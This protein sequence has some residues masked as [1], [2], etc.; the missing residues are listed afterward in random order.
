MGADSRRK[1]WPKRK[2]GEA[3]AGRKRDDTPAVESPLPGEEFV[4]LFTSSQR[5]LY[6][7][8]LS[9][10]GNPVEAEEVLQETSLIIWRK[11]DRFEL[12]TNFFAWA[13]QIAKYEVLKFRE[14]RGKEKLLF[15][16]EFIRRVSAEAIH[17]ADE[18]EARRHALTNCLGKLS[19]KDRELIQSR[20]APGK[21]GKSV[22][23][24]LGRPANSVYQSLGRIRRSLL[25]C[26]RRQLTAEAGP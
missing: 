2:N 10:I 21:S 14:R 5:R 18:M 4:Q 15:S 6:T 13:C 1:L 9:Q 24:E 12:G 19:P 3:V 7:F 22:S 25:E 8:I 23:Q 20:Y 26:I 17:N 11:F 16:D